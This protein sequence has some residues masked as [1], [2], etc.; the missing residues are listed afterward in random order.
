MDEMY[1]DPQIK[2]RKPL[3]IINGYKA[4]QNDVTVTAIRVQGLGEF[5]YDKKF[6]TID[7]R[8]G[9][10]EEISLTPV[11]WAVLAN[12]IPQMLQM[13]CADD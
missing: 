6:R 3:N 8:S 2:P 5:Y 10:G 9:T 12:R 1:E 7:W 13:L 4:E 11:D